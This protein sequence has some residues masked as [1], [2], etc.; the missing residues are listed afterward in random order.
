M[1]GNILWFGRLNTVKISIL[2]KLII[3]ISIKI[4]RGFVFQKINQSIPNLYG[5]AEHQE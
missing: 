3:T 5:I 4:P 1:V 2:P